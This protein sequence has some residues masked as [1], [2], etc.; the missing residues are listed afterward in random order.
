MAQKTELEASPAAAVENSA[1]PEI[2]SAEPPSPN[3]ASGYLR[4]RPHTRIFLIVA[5]LVLLV[6]GFL[7]WRYFSSYEST[8]DAQVDGH[9]MPVSARISGYV[10]K[11]N[12]GR[13]SVRAVGR[14]P[15]RNRS[16][17]LSGCRGPGARKRRLTP[18]PPLSPSTS[19]F[20]SHR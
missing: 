19:T 14:D 18:R 4:E 3:R 8:D 9:L 17:R 15:R 5:V 6:G 13:Q 11:V 16:A 12:V 7:A 2:H 1:A 20:R 10:S